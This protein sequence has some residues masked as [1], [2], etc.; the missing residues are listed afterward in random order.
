[1]SFLVGGA[2]AA[3]VALFDLT[4]R[5]RF[6]PTLGSLHWWLLR[7]LLD[8]I[9]GAAAIVLVHIAALEVSGASTPVIWVITGATAAQIVP[10]LQYSGGT[11]GTHINLKD[12]IDRGRLPLEDDIEK[13]S[14]AANA[15][16]DR[17]L[18]DALLARHVTPETLAAEL[19]ATM[20]GCRALSTKW[21]DTGFIE[22][23]AQGGRSERVR[24][25]LLVAHA[26]EMQL[27]GTVRRLKRSR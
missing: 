6:R 15:A 7:L 17:R 3:V 25:R 5:R 2:A 11:Q 26:R 24:T 19:I 13:A 14:A 8:G 9:Q 27:L 21:E 22:E 16:S 4:V 10:S 12:F 1:M 23:V 18:T 20:K